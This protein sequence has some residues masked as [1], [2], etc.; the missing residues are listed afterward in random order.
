MLL[1]PFFGLVGESPPRGSTPAQ[2]ELDGSPFQEILQGV[3]LAN[4]EEQSHGSGYPSLA[5]VIADA[6][7]AE[8]S[9]EAADVVPQPATGSQNPGL[10]RN[11]SG[12]P[13][14]GNADTAHIPPE[15]PIEP[16]LTNG[17]TRVTPQVRRPSG[18]IEGPSESL[19]G[20]SLSS[21]GPLNVAHEA[22]PAERPNP[23]QTA[24]PFIEEPDANGPTEP[25]NPQPAGQPQPHNPTFE[26]VETDPVRDDT[27]LRDGLPAAQPAEGETP[28]AT[29]PAPAADHAG[30]D[31][32]GIDF[33]ERD[34]SEAP[35][36]AR[37][38]DGE[39]VR[40]AV[41][42]NPTPQPAASL[43]GRQDTPDRPAWVG[44]DEPVART[45]DV[46]SLEDR[47]P[48]AE[49]GR[50][51]RPV[52]TPEGGT[53]SE[54]Q[55]TDR[56]AAP[57][58][59]V[60]LDGPARQTDPELTPSPRATT[61][62]PGP[63]LS[64]TN[65]AARQ[66]GDDAQVRIP[67]AESDLPAA[68]RGPSPEGEQ[69]VYRQVQPEAA[70]QPRNP[71][72]GVQAEHRVD[73]PTSSDRPA[74][75]TSPNPVEHRAAQPEGTGWT[76]EPLA[77]TGPDPS[78]GVSPAKAPVSDGSVERAL[79]A[80]GSPQVTR[81]VITALGAQ[82]ERPAQEPGTASSS[83]P[84]DLLR[85]MDG[86]PPGRVSGTGLP[87]AE[88]PV[89]DRQPAPQ[90]R[91][92]AEAVASLVDRAVSAVERESQPSVTTANTG[93][94]PVVDRLPGG[95]VVP[96]DTHRDAFPARVEETVISPENGPAR[97]S[98]PRPAETAALD[99]DPA[100]ET[101]L[102]DL[103]PA[104]RPDPQVVRQMST[105][106]ESGPVPS[107]G[108]VRG[109][110]ATVSSVDVAEPPAQ[111]P[112]DVQESKVTNQ[113]VRGARF[114][115]R[116]GASQVTLRLDPPELG[117]VTIRLSSVDKALS[118]EIRVESRMVQE[119]VSRNLG[120]LRESLGSQGIQLENI[121]VS[122]ESGNRSGVDRDGGAAHR[123]E[124]ADRD[125]QPARDRDRQPEQQDDRQEQLR[126]QAV[127]D[128]NVDYVA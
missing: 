81:D 24:L 123:R 11:A 89:V 76:P 55:R 12:P 97:S 121:D 34:D 45:P 23:M 87:A 35:P 109:G 3:Q 119:I 99:G 77:R 28:D 30:R 25:S 47:L 94:R 79:D 116:E 126:R 31:D 13:P 64:D 29:A 70:N 86:R 88:T 56:Q 113:I 91:P 108:A 106:P 16:G 9:Q 6:I 82:Q 14:P 19:E 115:T 8:S 83:V 117:E 66:E 98:Q 54:P 100:V 10:E 50:D 118:G 110:H 104:D 27:R 71:E 4:A 90:G 62:S 7:S 68:N 120:E 40:P 72:A 103:L 80:L 32:T 84:A 128:G 37:G 44:P 67:F 102:K 33:T 125:G 41:S 36:P 53:G 57:T 51:R 112:T 95:Q 59:F 48:S 15:V 49:P 18:S 96:S 69:P 22:D 26:T 5:E 73:T 114:L 111:A 85:S 127:Q 105:A 92:A 17:L 63:S 122:V 65:V 58:P 75:P 60:R 42:G 38:Q 101:P 61:V 78:S 107:V 74:T 43:A 39:R 52:E 124:T 1:N 20:P 21:E 2:G 46:A 93:E